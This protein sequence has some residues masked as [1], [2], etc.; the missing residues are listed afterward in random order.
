MNDN[1]TRS[2]H[3]RRSQ[4]TAALGFVEAFCVR[5]DVAP[6]DCLRLTLIV[7]ELFT[8]AIVHGHGGDSDAPLRVE[9]HAQS[10][11]LLLHFEDEA[12]PFDPLRYLAESAPD[13]DRPVAERQ[14]GGLGLP[15][16]AA[17]CERFDYARVG[18]RNWLRLSIRREA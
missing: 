1:E 5:Q 2:F 6:A 11:H 7:E 3:A 9:L 17:M 13:L 16:V 18:G 14:V 12:P 4:L 15:L 10:T 8:N